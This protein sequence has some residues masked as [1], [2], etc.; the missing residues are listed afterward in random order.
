[1]PPHSL[2][3][4][5]SHCVFTISMLLVLAIILFTCTY[6][7]NLCSNGRKVKGRRKHFL[8]LFSYV[9]LS[10]DLLSLAVLFILLHVLTLVLG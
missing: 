9:V 7:F 2:E 3:I 5:A 10:L 6:G 8:P 1:M 4:I